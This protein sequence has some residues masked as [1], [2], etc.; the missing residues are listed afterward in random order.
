MAYTDLDNYITLDAST[1]TYVDTAVTAMRAAFAQATADKAEKKHN[2]SNI[3]KI[4]AREQ[5]ES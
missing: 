3:F 4:E 2:V 5:N 1:K